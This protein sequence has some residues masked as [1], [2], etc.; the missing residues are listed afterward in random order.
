MSELINPRDILIV[1]SICNCMYLFYVDRL[2]RVVNLLILDHSMRQNVVK[3]FSPSLNMIQ[4]NYVG[5]RGL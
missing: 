5:Q 4:L 1:F 2:F 3:V